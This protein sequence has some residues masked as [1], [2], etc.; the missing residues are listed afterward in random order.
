MGTLHD[1]RLALR[2]LLRTPGYTFAAVVTLALTIG[3]NSAIFSAVYAVLL[4]PLPI[5]QPENLVI[6]WQR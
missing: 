4:K 2:N 6:C 1:A 3:A 5:R